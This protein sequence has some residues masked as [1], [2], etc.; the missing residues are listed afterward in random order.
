MPSHPQRCRRVRGLPPCSDTDRDRGG[1][2]QSSMG[3]AYQTQALPARKTRRE[4]KG[5]MSAFF[6][7]RVS[8]KTQRLPKAQLVCV[9]LILC[10]VVGHAQEPNPIRLPMPQTDIGRPLMQVLKDRSSTRTFSPARLP[11]QTVS[12]L[13]WAA[14]G[15]NRP[16]SGKRTAP[17]AM[18]WQETDIYVATADGLYIYDAK[19]QQ[20]DAVS[21]DDVGAWTG[22]QSFVKDAPLN[23]VYVADLAK[24]GC[25]TDITSMVTAAACVSG[26]FSRVLNWD[27]RQG[28]TVRAEK[29]FRPTLFGADG[30]GHILQSYAESMAVGW[31]AG[32]AARN[33]G[34][35]EYGDGDGSAVGDRT[36]S[37]TQPCCASHSSRIIR[38]CPAVVRCS[39]RAILLMRS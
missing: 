12:N 36:Y 23:L 37:S 15:V 10:P 31:S 32:G 2:L 22:T 20:L 16:D 26:P 28:R 5:K 11:A 27:R 4:R 18:N 13:L 24:T 21:R 33:S 25:A 19:T 6:T 35:T 29:K 30:R 38:I 3:V 39:P 8:A 14:F 17:S 34:A 1:T 9:I 7:K